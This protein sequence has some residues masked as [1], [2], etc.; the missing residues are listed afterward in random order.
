MDKWARLTNFYME[1]NEELHKKNTTEFLN[2]LQDEID[3]TNC[4]FG[5][6]V[7]I[8]IFFIVVAIILLP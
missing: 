1:Y 5:F 6:Y 4:D 8:V 3:E 7:Q 2:S